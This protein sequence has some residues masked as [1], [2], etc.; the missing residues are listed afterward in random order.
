MSTFNRYIVTVKVTS[1]GADHS[2][3]RIASFS[4]AATSEETIPSS[5]P[6]KEIAH[7]SEYEILDVEKQNY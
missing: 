1:S 6:L 5:L 3:N 4:V 2:I 7:V